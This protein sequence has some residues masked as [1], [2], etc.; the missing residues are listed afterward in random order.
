M[1]DPSQMEALSAKSAPFAGWHV[2]VVAGPVSRSVD[3]CVEILTTRTVE[4]E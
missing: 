2:R 4:A 3:R 1:S